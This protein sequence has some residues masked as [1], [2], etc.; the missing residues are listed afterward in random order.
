MYLLGFLLLLVFIVFG[1]AEKT[2]VPKEPLVAEEPEPLFEEQKV[3]KTTEEE[4]IGIKSAEEEISQVAEKAAS[5]A[6]SSWTQRKVSCA[7]SLF[8]THAHFDALVQ[9]KD[10]PSHSQWVSLTPQE[11]EK[12]MIEHKVGCAVLFVATLDMDKQFDSMRESLVGLDVGFLP[13][14][15]AFDGT[16]LSPEMISKIHEGREEAFFGIGELAFYVEPLIGTS[17]VADPWPAIFEYAAKE[18]LFL[19]LHP[20]QQ[21]ASDVEKMLSRYPNTKV[22]LHGFESLDT[23]LV[24]KWLRNYKNLYW[25]YDLATMFDGY[26]YR[27]Q[28]AADFIKWYEPNKEQYL[29]SVRNKLLPLLEAAPDRVMWGTDVVAD[30]HVEPEVYSRLIEFSHKLIDSL[31]PQYRDNYAYANAQRIFD[32]GIVFEK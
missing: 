9:S 30:W 13:F 28:N 31:P 16:K 23:G 22:I 5:E 4:P 25:T 3:N 26:L 21:Q 10:Y 27:V 14:F 2:L 19:M 18:N 29:S 1:C 17:L 20:T 15:I 8:D 32:S 7:G 12:R 6:E 24:E 11:L